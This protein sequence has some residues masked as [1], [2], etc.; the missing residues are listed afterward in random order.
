M[1]RR[2]AVVPRE[3]VVLKAAGG[4]AVCCRFTRAPAGLV[5]MASRG[6]RVCR[7][8]MVVTCGF[9]GPPPTRAETRSAA[10]KIYA[11]GA[12]HSRRGWLVF[13]SLTAEIVEDADEVR[14][15]VKQGPDR[16]VARSA[17]R[18]HSITA[19]TSVRQVHDKTLT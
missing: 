14:P 13:L 9:G 6:A 16:F 4:A 18:W 7:G 8:L 11:G 2:S 17:R 5:M 15:S 19:S 12:R 3:L 10:E 1:P